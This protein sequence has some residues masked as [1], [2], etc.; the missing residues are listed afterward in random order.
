[1]HN[2]RIFLFLIL[3]CNF[4]SC[5]QAEQISFVDGS[6]SNEYIQS[7]IP[8][9]SLKNDE[10]HIYTLTMSNIGPMKRNDESSQRRNLQASS[11]TAKPVSDP[12]LAPI[13]NPTASPT[14][15]FK[16][17]QA[18]VPTFRP[19]REPTARPSSFN[20]PGTAGSP[21]VFMTMTF[22]VQL[23]KTTF[24][25]DFNLP[26]LTTSLISSVMETFFNFGDASVNYDSLLKL[27]ESELSWTLNLYFNLTFPLNSPQYVK[28]TARPINIYKEMVANYTAYS[29]FTKTCCLPDTVDTTYNNLASQ[30]KYDNTIARQF[31]FQNIA[32]SNPRGLLVV[33]TSAPT[34]VPTN[35][36]GPT[37][38]PT[39]PPSA[40]VATSSGGGGS[41]N[42]GYTFIIV[43]VA[44]GGVIVAAFIYYLYA[45]K[46]YCFK[47]LDKD[48][49]GDDEEDEEEDIAAADATIVKP[50][51]KEMIMGPNGVMI[52]ADS[53]EGQ[54][55]RSR[56]SEVRNKSIA[57]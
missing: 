1:M 56:K 43:G 14:I 2:F 20:F 12:T 57:S 50:V 26:T 10:Q 47:I 42:V 5:L 35:S 30:L 48:E 7:I 3:A 6:E 54:L 39:A 19:T 49:G 16:P 36:P 45:T 32:F 18:P 28:Y 15:S 40:G 4:F 8:E 25:N 52:E 24:Y 37:K 51:E 21:Y 33:E 46:Q 9:E 13:L 27:Q 44:G 23:R 29:P 53:P 55:L 34:L 38:E 11:P 31:F 17:T 41:G 22:N